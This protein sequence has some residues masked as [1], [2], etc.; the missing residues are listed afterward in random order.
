MT[1]LRQICPTDGSLLFAGDVNFLRTA[2]L[3]PLK[4]LRDGQMAGLVKL[5]R[6]DQS[7]TERPEWAVNEC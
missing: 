5:H 1:C 2:D 3:H 4:M 6:G 7:A